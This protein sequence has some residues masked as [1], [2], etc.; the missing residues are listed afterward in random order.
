MRVHEINYLIV[1]TIRVLPA[2]SDRA[3]CA[4]LEM[5]PHQFPSD[6]AKRFVD[7]GYLRQNVSAVTVFLHHFLQSAHLTFDSAKSGKV[8]RFHFRINGNRFSR[9]GRR[10]PNGAT[11]F[12]SVSRGD[13]GMPGLC[14]HL[15]SS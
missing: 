6:A 9:A 3:R 5:I 7:R 1:H 2:G 8:P 14:W 11:T 15:V 4:V 12:R 10:I 13:F